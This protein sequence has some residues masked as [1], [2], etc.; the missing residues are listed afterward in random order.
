MDLKFGIPTDLNPDP[1]TRQRFIDYLDG[2]HR[3]PESRHL[4]LAGHDAVGS[5][6]EL[7]RTIRQLKKG[8][9]S[10]EGRAVRKWDLPT[11]VA[12]MA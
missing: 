12:N 1:Q 3:S 10:K 6:G 9:N 8:Y 5:A 4:R 7:D 2:A 11:T